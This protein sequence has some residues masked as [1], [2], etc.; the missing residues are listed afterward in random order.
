MVPGRKTKLW[1][2]VVLV[3]FYELLV[4]DEFSWIGMGNEY[5]KSSLPKGYNI[6][7]IDVFA[8]L[9][10]GLFCSVKC[11]MFDNSVIKSTLKFMSLLLWMVKL[12]VL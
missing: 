10:R 2:K 12:Q 9:F 5:Q 8:P 7:T 1:P 3:R 4:S 11:R 6:Q